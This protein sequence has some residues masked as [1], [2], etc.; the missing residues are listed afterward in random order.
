MGGMS[1]DIPARW[2]WCLN[3][4]R[5]EPDEGCANQFRLGPYETKE[6]ASH[7]IELAHERAEV[8]DEEEKAFRDG[9][10]DEDGEHAGE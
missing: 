5:V 1:D 9:R 4:A 10:R 3:H 7:A 6:D 8:W 2:W